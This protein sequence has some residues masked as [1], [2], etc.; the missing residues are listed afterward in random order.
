MKKLQKINLFLFPYVLTILSLV[1]LYN[2]FHWMF[3]MILVI[4]FVAW[5]ITAKDLERMRIMEYL[6]ETK[7]DPREMVATQ[8]TIDNIMNY[9]KKWNDD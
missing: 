1:V 3:F 5:A 2:G 4:A 6:E 7:V 9:S 8:E